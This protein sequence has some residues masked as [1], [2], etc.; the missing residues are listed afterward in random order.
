MLDTNKL[1]QVREAKG[2]DPAEIARRAGM[3]RQQWFNLETGLRPDPRVSTV[4]RLARAL[5]C[6]VNELLTDEPTKQLGKQRGRK[7]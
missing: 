7:Q 5:G 3:T 6:D 2:Y 4:Q 1:R